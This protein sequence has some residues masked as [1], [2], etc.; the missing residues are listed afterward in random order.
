M[1]EMAVLKADVSNRYAVSSQGIALWGNTLYCLKNTCQCSYGY[2][3][4]HKLGN[5][6]VRRSTTYSCNTYV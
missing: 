4:F 6:I 1:S 5:T 3:Y 2:F